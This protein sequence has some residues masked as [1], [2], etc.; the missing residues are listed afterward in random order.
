M[1]TIH[2]YEQPEGKT[3]I[4]DPVD[5]MIAK[6]GKENKPSCKCGKMQRQCDLR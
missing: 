5:L 4:S 1:K 3:K 2:I 6:T